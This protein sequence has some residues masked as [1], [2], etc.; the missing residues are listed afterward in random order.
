MKIILILLNALME[1][2]WRYVSGWIGLSGSLYSTHHVACVL[3]K[4][5]VCLCDPEDPW[6]ILT[7][8]I[9]Q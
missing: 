4:Q 5:L 6:G 1:N 9:L 7:S 8:H 3:S 2:M